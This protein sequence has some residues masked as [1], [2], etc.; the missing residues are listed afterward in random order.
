[1]LY[2]FNNMITHSLLLS[3]MVMGIMSCSD[4][5][6]ID[7]PTDSNRDLTY[8]YERKESGTLQVYAYDGKQEVNLVKDDTHDYW[9]VKVSPDKKKFLCYRSPKNA[10]VNSFTVA[11]LIVFNIDGTNG[12]VILPRNVY[13]WELQA[14]AKWSP[15]GT[16]ILA[17]A[18]CKDPEINDLV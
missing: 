6:P 7:E 1:M 2:T 14:H 17:S 16:K 3:I 12:K 18:K 4:N 8:F 11:E 9:W 13:D 15:D 5:I 10:G